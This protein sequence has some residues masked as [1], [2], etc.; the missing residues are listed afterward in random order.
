MLKNMDIR[1]LT[2]ERCYQAGCRYFEQ[3]AVEMLMADDEYDDGDNLDEKEYW[4]LVRGTGIYRVS[5]S[6]T[7]DD[8][9]KSF[10]CNCPAANVYHTACKHVVALLKEIQERQEVREGKKG[11]AAKNGEA[12][13]NLFAAG[14]LEMKPPPAPLTLLPTFVVEYFYG[15][16]RLWLEFRLGRER[17]YV[18]KSLG[19]L[20]HKFDQGLTMYFGKQLELE[21][22]DMIFADPV[23]ERLWQLLRSIWQDETSLW[24]YGSYEWSTGGGSSRFVKKQLRLTPSI[25]AEF[26]AIMKD[27]P[28]RLLL[29]GEEMTAR[30]EDDMPPLTIQLEEAATGGTVTF[31]EA[32]EFHLLERRGSAALLGD[33]IYRVP[34]AK[35]DALARLAKAFAKG[36]TLALNQQQLRQFFAQVLTPLRQVAEVKI[37]AA[38][39][40]KYEMLPLA[41]EVYFDR[42]QEGLEARLA[43]T[44]GDVS[45]D[46]LADKAPLRIGERQLIRDPRAEERLRQLF[47]AFH[48]TLEEG[49]YR[50]TEED[51]VY[52][53]L[54]GGLPQLN[55]LAAVFFADSFRRRPVQ[56]MPP[57]K[58]GVGINQ[59]RLLEVQ[60]KA[61]DLDFSE[62][63]AILQSYRLKRRYH[64]LSDGSFVTL[65]GAQLD[66]LADLAATVRLAE[67]QEAVVTPLSQALYLDAAAREEKSLQLERSGDFRRLIQA[68]TMP[69]TG[70][71]PVPAAVAP[72]L[73]DY[74]V[75]GFQWLMSLTAYGLGGI[76]ADDMGLGKTLE[77]I[78]FLLAQRQEGAPPTLVVTPTSLMYNWL[79]E[80]ARFAPEL[81]AAAIAGGKK[82]RQQK[83]ADA[84]GLDVIVTT[85]NL[86]KNDI[87]DYAAQ[88]FRF[89]VLDEAQHIKNPATHNAK[90]VKKI[91]AAGRFALTGT[92]IENT[93]TELWSIFDF[94]MPGY[95]GSHPLFRSRYETPIVRDESGPAAA[96]LRRHIA[97]F[98]LRRMKKDVLT[99]LPDK[100]ESKIINEMTPQ[101]EK[102]YKAWFVRSQKEFSAILK[103]HGVDSGRIRILALLTRL[104]QIACDPGLFL[105]DYDGG[106][107][108]LELLAEVVTDA[109]AAGH[110][111]LIFSQFTAMLARIADRLRYL[112]FTYAYL[113]GQTP[114][115]ERLRL[116]QEFNAGTT[117]LFLISLKAGGTGLNLTG[118]DMVIHYDPWW[119][120]AVE[121]QAT[122]RAYRI[123]QENKVQV[124]KFITKDTIEEK[125]FDLQERKKA[126]IDQMIQPGE[127]FLARLAE[128]ELRSLF[129]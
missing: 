117:P 121:E 91:R 22:Q 57:V 54:Q 68:V 41:A 53:F 112:G 46:P 1:A 8:R 90:A 32:P 23:S 70:A 82:E 75:Q 12:L 17:L 93:L 25:M 100:V 108:K 62:I 18:I 124:L 60:F 13:L 21:R 76:L 49:R 58:V 64:R 97:P 24:T 47:L 128:D 27:T 95:L 11:A 96:D 120:P 56:N 99:E 14:Q 83:L 104:R 77:V 40:R 106:S 123:G 110:R 87:E 101:Q 113:D 35:G 81:R 10:Q 103:E 3:G 43:F 114:A 38:F 30:I 34:P 129:R 69:E 61:Q 20:L 48:F 102:L 79:E 67:A 9:I 72:V 45:Y 5:T 2:E 119:N 66:A 92:P 80:I 59:D 50:L 111:L 116:V 71:W 98:V 89:C 78:A 36:D 88:T 42:W 126:L 19:E 29:E 63:A 6:L 85:Y 26:F 15:Q 94:L 55:Q 37:A 125:I 84:A 4:A 52:D 109:I 33:V 107:G 122:D 28:F 118:A 16:Q 65:D 51:A 105:E 127:T 73:R 7:K 39:S 115:I 86:L 74:Q 31:A 44:Y